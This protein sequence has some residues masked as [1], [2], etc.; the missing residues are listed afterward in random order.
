MGRRRRSTALR[1]GDAGFSGAGRS[2]AVKLVAVL[3]AMLGSPSQ[4]LAFTATTTPF[5]HSSPGSGALAGRCTVPGHLR[6]T[7]GERHVDVVGEAVS[8]NVRRIRYLVRNSNRIL[9]SRA[10]EAHS[11]VVAK[12]HHLAGRDTKAELIEIEGIRDKYRLSQA[13]PRPQ[14]VTETAEWQRLMA[15]GKYMQLSKLRD[16]L[17][18]ESRSEALTAEFEGTYLDYSRNQ[19]SERT[20]Q[21]LH[22]LAKRQGLGEKIKAM[23]RGDKI[24]T[25]EGRAVL[26]TALRAARDDEAV[27]V[28]GVN[29]LEQVHDS[30][31]KVRAFSDSVRSG[32]WRG[33]TG[34]K[35]KNFVA[36]GIGGSYLGPEF[37]HE[38][39]KTEEYPGQDENDQYSLRFLSNVD[40]VDVRRTLYDLD[41][42]ETLCIIIS[43]TFTTA[44]TML[45]ARTARQW[46]WDS[47]GRDSTVVSSHM[48]ACASTSAGKLIN[49]FGIPHEQLFPFWDWVGGRYS[50]SSSVGALPLSL[51]YGYPVFEKFLAGARA[52]DNHF[53]H[54][55]WE[56]NLP[57]ILGLL[58]IWN[59]S[60][61][62][63]RTRTVLPYAEALLKLPAH[64]QQLAMESNGKRVTK[65]GQVL[66]YVV[67]PID[68][69]EP[70]TNGQHSFFQLLHQGQTSPAEFIGF[71]ESQHHLHVEG[72]PI[73]SHDELMA[74]FFA[75]PD[76][77]ALGKSPSQLLA[78]GCPQHLIP[79]RTFAGNRPSLSLLLPKVNAYYLGQILALYEHRTTVEG[80]MW[81]IN[82]FDQWGVELGKKLASNIRDK[83]Q[84]FRTGEEA[85]PEGLNPST[86]RLLSR[87][88]EQSDSL[89][90]VKGTVNHTS[91]G[92]RIK[93]A[94]KDGLASHTNAREEEASLS[95][96]KR[97]AN[98]FS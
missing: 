84:K 34:K 9:K 75:Q 52:M 8:A 81:D 50:V 90:K 2:L 71:I 18:D 26:H 67:G 91:R 58:S 11:N 65:S 78:E 97:R 74:N 40:P 7:I 86:K 45:N 14:S 29:V 54:S 31:D 87:Y 89:V 6:M 10:T 22:D 15:H 12:L 5:I 73:S 68:F 60:F 72:E 48:C 1:D 33:H 53:L 43:K 62:D 64:I 59:V 98:F 88:L 63:Y 92:S 79:H 82:S 70:G 30:L 95:S 27:F 69:G 13:D 38:A 41:P 36:I 16:L 17:T 4:A 80:F 37:V 47:M 44:E 23:F 85:H 28:D 21:L 42:E 77:L 49:E 83:M 3:V 61:L 25:S 20:M 96:S 32:K 76:A 94:I 51:K 46:L 35:I 66:D 39:F 55:P 56:K 57:V 19:V 24:N 93:K